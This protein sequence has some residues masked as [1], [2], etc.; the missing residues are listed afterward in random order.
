MSLFHKTQQIKPEAEASAQPHDSIATPNTT[1]DK[2]AEELARGWWAKRYNEAIP[3]EVTAW[4]K[5]LTRA[6]VRRRQTANSLLSPQQLERIEDAKRL[7]E[8]KLRNIDASLQQLRDQQEWL[9]QYEH[10][11]QELTEHR[12]RLFEVNKQLSA[13][14]EEQKE[15]ERF[16]AFESVQSVFQRLLLLEQQAKENKQAQSELVHDME[17]VQQTANDAEKMLNQL[18][19]EQAEA[20]RQMI[21]V[22]DQLEEANRILGAKMVLD[23]DDRSSERFSETINQQRLI[24]AKECEEYEAELNALQEL[25]TQQSSIRQTMEPHQRLMEHGELALAL[26]DQLYELKTEL[27]KLTRDQQQQLYQQQ[28]SNNALNRIF[29]DYNGVENDIKTLNDELQLHRQNNSGRSSYALQERA[30]QLKSRRQMLISAQSLWHRIQSGYIMIEEKAQVLNSL[31]LNIDNLQKNIKDLEEKIGPMRQRCHEKEYTLTLSKS[32]NVIQLRSD[33]REGVGCT[34]CGATHHPYHSDTMLEQNK[35]INELHT[36][37]ELLQAELIA[38]EEQLRQLHLELAAKLARQE[39]EEET[40]SQLRERQT[41][42][43]KEWGIFS[44][45]DRSLEDCSPSTNL[46]ART[47]LLRQFIEN[48]NRDADDAQKELDEF[49]FHQTRIN[50][51]TETI[52]QKE[53]QKSDLTLR[54]NEVNTS[55]QVLARQT[56]HTRQVHAEC[57]EQ[58]TQLYERLGQLITLKDWYEEWEQSHESLRRRIEQMLERWQY[59]NEDIQQMQNRQK[60]L[61]LSLEYKRDTCAFLN[62]LGAQVRDD[63]E[64]RSLIRK[65]GEKTYKNTL[66]ENEVKDYFDKNYQMLLDIQK[67]VNEQEKAMQQATQQLAEMTGRQQILTAQGKSLDEEVIARRSQLDVWIRKFNATHP[68]VQYS[69]L[70]RTFDC[71]RDWSATREKVRAIR[72]EAMLEQA[73]VDALHRNIVA[74]Q[75]E[76]IHPSESDKTDLKASLVAQQKQLEQQREDVLVQ[77]ANHRIALDTHNECTARLKSEEEELYAIT[78]RQ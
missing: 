63:I 28:Q 13:I 44:N 19:G 23:L 37:F 5:Q 54:L 6:E 61:E 3:E 49:N 36:D 57:H 71:E 14:A 32:Q 21:M 62:T 18:K 48:A 38:K 2:T 22:R 46:D 76:G 50:E 52:T 33:L 35:L 26:L 65:D 68:P 39:V 8:T 29:S 34:V 45:L 40:L 51:I 55:C 27:N 69:E 77:L 9:R 41:D 4:I 43:I 1:G 24:L 60:R 20:S 10:I 58:F 17:K 78:N 59:T 56:E 47:V 25:I 12:N 75:A 7:A 42:D 74:L 15:L 64:Q 11:N 53:Q 70:A 30:M 66:G 67:T 31:R 16:E 73:R 72:I